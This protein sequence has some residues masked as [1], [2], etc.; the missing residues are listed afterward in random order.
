MADTGLVRT[1][2]GRL[3]ADDERSNDPTE[4]DPLHL[5][6]P[7]ISSL[8]YWAGRLYVPTDLAG[9]RGDLIVLRA[10]GS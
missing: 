1:I 7:Q 6:L 10:P 2:A 3:V 5:N 8:D 9:G 4:S